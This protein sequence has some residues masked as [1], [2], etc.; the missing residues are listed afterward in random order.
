[1]CRMFRRLYPLF[2]L[3]PF[4]GWLGKRIGV[5][6]PLFSSR[7]SHSLHFPAII[8]VIV[9]DNPGENFVVSERECLA[10]MNACKLA[11]FAA[12]WYSARNRVFAVRTNYVRHLPALKCHIG[13]PPPQSRHSTPVQPVEISWCPPAYC[14]FHVHPA[15]PSGISLCCIKLARLART[16]NA[17][18]N[19]EKSVVLLPET[20]KDYRCLPC[21][22]KSFV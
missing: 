6:T 13:E 22:A 20:S 17:F 1:M 14:S 5:S 2:A 3:E 11:N 9:A 18:A 7:K 12:R 19:H 8:G 16:H 4:Q 15:S 21:P 10:T